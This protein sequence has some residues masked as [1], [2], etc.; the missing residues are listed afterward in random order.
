MT[1]ETNKKEGKGK[2]RE[3]S[4]DDERTKARNG[5]YTLQ[6]QLHFPQ[7]YLT[8]NNKPDDGN[9][10]WT[11]S[12]PYDAL[13]T[14]RELFKIMHRLGLKGSLTRSMREDMS[15]EWSTM[16]TVHGPKELVERF[17]HF[18]IQKWTQAR[19]SA[20]VFDMIYKIGELY[21]F[22]LPG[23]SEVSRWNRSLVRGIHWRYFLLTA[24]TTV[25]G[26]QAEMDLRSSR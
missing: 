11:V 5:T 21:T 13:T 9:V 19:Y 25:K 17:C 22:F 8:N 23:G 6:K 18:D 10:T 7:L 1:A 26:H 12:I 2:E 15:G 3:K 24:I 20:L 16:I 4:T 14:K